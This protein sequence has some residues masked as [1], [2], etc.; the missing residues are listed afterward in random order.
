MPDARKPL[1]TRSLVAV[2]IAVV[3]VIVLV[4][5]FVISSH[6]FTNHGGATTCA[7]FIGLKADQRKATVT[8][9]LRERGQATN[10]PNITVM[11]ASSLLFCQTLAQQ[12][13]PIAKMYGD[14]ASATP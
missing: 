13:D 7:E 11:L 2:A 12:T 3:L 14:G 6:S 5:G 1:P 10:D 8:Q 9:M 4:A